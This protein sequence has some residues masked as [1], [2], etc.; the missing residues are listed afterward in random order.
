MVKMG[1][2]GITE[3]TLDRKFR[4]LKKTYRAIKDNNKKSS[5]GRGRI[6]WEYFDTFEE[7]FSDDRTIN[8][9]PTL[10][11]MSPLEKSASLRSLA[12]PTTSPTFGKIPIPLRLATQSMFFKPISPQ[13]Y[14]IATPSTSSFIEDNIVNEVKNSTNNLSSAQLGALNQNSS[15]DCSPTDSKHSTTS[16]V[17]NKQTCKDMNSKTA[18]ELRKKLLLVEQDRVTAINKLS[19]SINEN[20]KIQKERNELLKQLVEKI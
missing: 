14:D 11:S 6:T 5:T 18:Y 8:F 10:S 3:D 13:N 1:Y 19:D 7:I 4:N 20:N 2:K 9:G 17:Q 12:R 16:R 15:L